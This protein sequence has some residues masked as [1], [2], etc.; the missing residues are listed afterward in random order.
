MVVAMIVR[1]P[2]NR[3]LKEVANCKSTTEGL[4]QAEASKARQTAFFEGEIELPG[5]FRHTSQPYLKS[6]FVRRPQDVD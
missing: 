3:E 2:S 1:R 6:R 5:T 4:K